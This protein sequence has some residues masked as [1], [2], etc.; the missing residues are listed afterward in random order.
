MEQIVHELLESTHPV[1]V[2]THFR[3]AVTRAEAKSE[4]SEY[5]TMKYGEFDHAFQN[6]LNPRPPE[7]FGLRVE[8]LRVEG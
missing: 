2:L 1:H 6:R 3:R 7:V 8:G 5:D 4:A